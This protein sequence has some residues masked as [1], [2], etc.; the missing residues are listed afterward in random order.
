MDIKKSVEDWDRDVRCIP[1]FEEIRDVEYVRQSGEINMI[2]DD[3]LGTLKKKGLQS[4]WNWVHRCYKLHSSWATHY[5]KHL[6]YMEEHHGNRVDWCK[7]DYKFAVER[8]EIMIEKKQLQYRLAEL[9][10]RSAKFF[11]DMI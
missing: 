11:P 5:S 1:T 8:D 9:E 2:T 10:A 3:L 7:G 4:G 6:R